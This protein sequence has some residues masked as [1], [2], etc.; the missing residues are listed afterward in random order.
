M[1]VTVRVTVSGRPVATATVTPS[2]DGMFCV[3]P[4]VTCFLL[5]FSCGAAVLFVSTLRRVHRSA[6]R[7]RKQDD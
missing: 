6:Y 3:A 2:G 7:L 1:L 5:G 4:D